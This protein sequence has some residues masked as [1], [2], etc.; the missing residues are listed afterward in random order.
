M[1]KGNI[2]VV[3]DEPDICN[4]VRE[5]LEDEGF[6]VNL[7][8]NGEEAN[9]QREKCNPDLILLDIWMPD[10]DGISLLKQWNDAGDLNSLVIMMSGHGT[11]ETAVEATRLGAYDFLEK[12]LSLAKLILTIKH[13]LERNKL[14]SENLRLRQY[15]QRSVEL[16]GKSKPIL[17]LKEQIERIADH[18]TPVLI[19]GESGTDKELVARYLHSKSE[20]KDGPFVSVSV[21][22]LSDNGSGVELFGKESDSASY[23]GYLQQAEGGTLFLKDIADMDMTIQA[24]FHSAL[25]SQSF[26]R[27]DGVQ[28]ISLNT[29]IIAATR[30]S[31]DEKVTQGEFRNELFFQLNVIPLKIPPLRE[32]FEDVPELLE[33]Y[34]NYFV[35]QD[36][37]NYRHFTT[38]AQ[39]RLRTYSWPGNIRE[40]KNMIQRLLI[41]GSNDSIELEEVETSLGE[42]PSTRYSDDLYNFNMPLREARERFEKAYLEYQLKQANGSVSKIAKAVGMERTHL[43][44]KLKSLGIDIK[45]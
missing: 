20:S 24:K 30:Y 42:L 1:N 26:T 27:I 35:E 13:A 4:L 7:A 40:L 41:L 43:Y 8:G 15:S 36:G 14:Q 23:T 10:I 28:S 11:V 33:F 9:I 6:E 18:N 19:I 2:L 12:P 45:N 17:N 22:G 31:L 29:R 21:S 16:I 25:E 44:R 32:H 5:I 39:N 38:A 3:D 34:V 37:L